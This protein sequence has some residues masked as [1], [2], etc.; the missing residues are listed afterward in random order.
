MKTSSSSRE[1]QKV[2]VCL[3]TCAASRAIHLELV[4][5]QSADEFHLALRRF[6][7]VHGYPKL[8]VSDNASQFIA[9]ETAMKKLWKELTSSADVE[10][11]TSTHDVDWKKIPQV[12]PWMGGFYERLVGTVK[13]FLKKTLDG[14]CVNLSELR[15]ALAEITWMVN[16]RPLLYVEDDVSSVQLSPADLL[17]K[18]RRGNLP[19]FDEQEEPQSGAQNTVDKIVSRW[20]RLQSVTT[21]FWDHWRQGYLTSLR[22]KH[23][24]A[25][26]RNPSSLE[27]TLGSVVQIKDKLPRAQWRLGKLEKLFPSGDGKVRSVQLR[28][29]NGRFIIRPIKLLYP[30]EMQLETHTE[31]G[32]RN[33][34]VNPFTA[35][36]EQETENDEEFSGFSSQDVETV[37]KELEKYD[38]L[39]KLVLRQQPTPPEPRSKRTAAL[40]AQQKIRQTVADS[41]SWWEGSDEESE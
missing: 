17:G 5:N 27:P 31:H 41:P 14:L 6:F 11:L 7:A 29:A 36:V 10:N 39:E 40:K 34:Q 28:L 23:A 32:E 4:E 35:T 13:K 15:T 12:A 18:S 25:T 21:M 22:E 2:W 26:Q 37:S 8:I 3:F 38:K 20:K 24:N 19:T 1:L 16:S 30:L 33:K 9:V